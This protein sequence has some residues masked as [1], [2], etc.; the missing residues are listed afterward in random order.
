MTFN[1]VD[2]VWLRLKKVKILVGSF[3]KLKLKVDGPFRITNMIN[4]KAYQIDLSED[5]NISTTFNVTDLMLI[6]RSQTSPLM[7]VMPPQLRENEPK[8]SCG[9][10]IL[11]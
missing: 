7:K 10:L 6:T 1:V 5:Y 3:V 4:D 9:G 11:A 2:L 8:S